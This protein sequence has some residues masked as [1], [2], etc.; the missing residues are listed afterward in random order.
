M[1]KAQSKGN[2]LFKDTTTTGSEAPET[3]RVIT[4]FGEVIRYLD[5]ENIVI[6]YPDGT[7][8]SSDKRR[9]LWYT[10][11]TNGVK[12][13]RRIKDSIIFDDELRLKSESKVDPETNA[14]LLTREDGLL[15]VDYVDTA[16]Y[17]IFPD[18]TQI[19]TKNRPDGEAGRLTI[20]TKE[21]YVPVK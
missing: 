13:T 5:D 17:I 16:K 8:T 3:H 7:I 4:F 21:G 6:Y 9:G 14:T 12:R 11:N 1:P 15:M 19:L 18:G 20:V 10:T 2:G